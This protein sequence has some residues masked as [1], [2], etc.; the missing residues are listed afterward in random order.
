[1]PEGFTVVARTDD[2]EVNV[3]RLVE[4][5]GEEAVIVFT[6]TEYF[7]V[8]AICPHANGFLDE[9]TVHGCEIECPLHVG[10]F[11]LRT[12]EATQKPA[13]DSIPT[14]EVAID[15][16]EIALRKRIRTP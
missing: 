9:G 13:V 12:G 16:N 11:D 2:V 8:G 15:G 10:R 3:P 5:D 6:G 7:A 14:F 4:I 1:M